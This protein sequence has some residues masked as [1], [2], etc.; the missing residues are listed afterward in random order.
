MELDVCPRSLGLGTTGRNASQYGRIVENRMIEAI[1]VSA[2]QLIEGFRPLTDT[3]GYDWVGAVFGRFDSL[4]LLQFKGTLHLRSHDRAEFVQIIFDAGALTPHRNTSVLFGRFDIPAT[5]LVDPLWLVPS[6]KLNELTRAEYCRYH[7]RKHL[8][9]IASP[10]EGS[11]D[12]ASR[13]QVQKSLLARRVFADH[14]GAATLP[15]DLSSMSNEEGDFFEYGFATRFLRD[16]TGTEKLLRPDPDLGRD[17]LAL[18]LRPFGWASLAI[19]GTALRQHANDVI[20]V[21]VKERTFFPHRRHFVLVQYF[22]RTLRRLHPVS[23][24]IPSLAFAR[25]ANRSS[26]M[27]Q[28][29]TNLNGTKNR[30]APYAIPTEEDAAAFIRWMRRPPAA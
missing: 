30:W 19:K 16:C 29:V 22:D 10:K 15:L 28:M 27:Y 4:K 7:K 14:S 13:Y 9:F 1:E 21:L 23:W 6:L 3:G 18:T 17:M 20:A 2:T 26:G 25:L 8:H 5:D 24:L 12:A 11:R